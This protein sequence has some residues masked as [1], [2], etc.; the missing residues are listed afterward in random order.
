MRIRTPPAMTPPI[1]SAGPVA[2]MASPYG[3][4]SVS[5]GPVSPVGG[6]ASICLSDVYSAK[7]TLK[8]GTNVVA[9]SHPHT[10][11]FPPMT[12]HQGSGAWTPTPG[13]ACPTRGQHDGRPG[14][15][16]H[17]TGATWTLRHCVV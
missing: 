5:H 1:S 17:G 3:H 11:A 4:N 15:P 2:A 14:T 7:L 16:D 10:V 9:A 6:A 12:R 8:D 13:T